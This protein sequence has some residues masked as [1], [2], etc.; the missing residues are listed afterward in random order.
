[1]VISNESASYFAAHP[2]KVF[3]SW[4]TKD[5][6]GFDLAYREWKEWASANIARLIT[7]Y[8]AL[9]SIDS[10]GEFSIRKEIADIYGMHTD[11]KAKLDGYGK[12]TGIY[13]RNPSRVGPRRID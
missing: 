10:A 1:M 5:Y 2:V 12:A 3:D 13:L 6:D 11:I 4:A 7:D 9:G 8:D